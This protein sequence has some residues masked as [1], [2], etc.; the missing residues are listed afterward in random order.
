V[1]WAYIRSDFYRRILAA[2]ELSSRAPEVRFD[3][4]SATEGM[5]LIEA[6]RGQMKG[7]ASGVRDVHAPVPTA[8]PRG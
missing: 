2:I 7:E 3:H 6:L 1:L 4:V 8:T 5:E